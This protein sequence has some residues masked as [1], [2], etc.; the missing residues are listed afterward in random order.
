M[1]KVKNCGDSGEYLT[2]WY[3]VRIDGYT[4]NE[5]FTDGKLVCN[6]SAINLQVYFIAIHFGR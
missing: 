3:R 4:R 5:M 1:N 2:R 6:K